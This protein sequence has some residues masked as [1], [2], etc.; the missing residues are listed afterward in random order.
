MQTMRGGGGQAMIFGLYF[1]GLGVTFTLIYGDKSP[2]WAKAIVC[3]CWPI[4]C[5]G[6]LLLPGASDNG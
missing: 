3:M 5:V 1:I 6:A 2:W 4:A